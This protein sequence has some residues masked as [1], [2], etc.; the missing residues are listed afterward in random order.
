MKVYIIS[1]THW[2]HKNIIEYCNRPFK[3]VEEMNSIMIKNWNNTVGKNDLVIHLGDVGIGS[4]D[5]VSSIIHSL[6]GKKMLIMGNHD[7]FSENRYREMGFKTVSRFPI[8]WNKFFLLSHAPLQLTETTPYFNLY[9]H[10][11]NDERYIDTKTSKCVS[12]ERINYTP[13]FLFDTD[14]Q[15][16]NEEIFRKILTCK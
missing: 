15:E 9:G 10:V 5:K 6:N 3:T 8:L 14:R 16:Y 13:L 2:N 7:N 4:Y 11:H 1:D 12:V